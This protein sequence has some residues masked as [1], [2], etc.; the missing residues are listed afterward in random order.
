MNPEAWQKLS[1][2]LD[3]VLDLT[4]TDRAS[5]LALSTNQKWMD[6][7]NDLVKLSRNP[8]LVDHDNANVPDP[9]ASNYRAALE[10]FWRNYY[11]TVGNLPANGVVPLPVPIAGSIL[12]CCSEACH[13][14]KRM[15]CGS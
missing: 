14:S 9:T 5:L 6:A 2:L 11:I 4:E 7:V 15:L 12:N 1:P 3:Q 8:G 10:T 13:M